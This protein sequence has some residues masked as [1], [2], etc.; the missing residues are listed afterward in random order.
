MIYENRVHIEIMQ[1][2]TKK[3]LLASKKLWI[4]N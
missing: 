4:Y 2:D 1:V 3:N